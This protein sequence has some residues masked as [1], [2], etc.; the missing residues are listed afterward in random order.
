MQAWWAPRC[1]P[2]C[3]SSLPTGVGPMRWPAGPRH[4]PHPIVIPVSGDSR[5]PSWQGR[6]QHGGRQMQP[7]H[8]LHGRPR[9]TAQHRQ[10]R[11]VADLRNPTAGDHLWHPAARSVYTNAPSAVVHLTMSL[12]SSHLIGDHGFDFGATAAAYA[13][14]L[15]QERVFPSCPDFGSAPRAHADREHRW[16]HIEHLLFACPSILGTGGTLAATLLRDDLFKACF[17]SD[18]AS[19]VL[20]AAF[21]FDRTPVAAATA[22]LTPF[23][24]D[25]CCPGTSPPLAHEVAMRVSSR[26]VLAW[27]VVCGVHKAASVGVGVGQPSPS[28]L[29]V[30][31]FVVALPTVWSF[32]CAGAACCA[33]SCSAHVRPC[34]QGRGGR[35]PPGS[36]VMSDHLFI[37][38]FVDVLVDALAIKHTP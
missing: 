8:G 14:S 35:C 26:C 24:L 33:Y 10:P 23:L 13:C 38:F 22:C 37:L 2:A 30:R 34:A 31:P 1:S 11:W 20:L 25:R 19:A 16:C 3:P 7:T 17:G 6:G 4:L 15:C 18:H 21:P 27:C 9:E 5:S 12:R 32:V 36:G 28:C 29:V